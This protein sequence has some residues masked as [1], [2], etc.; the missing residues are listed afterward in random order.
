MLI[1]IF[2][3]SSFDVLITNLWMCFFVEE[4]E[5]EQRLLLQLHHGHSCQKLHVETFIMWPGWAQQDQLTALIE[6]LTVILECI[7]VL[8]F[9]LAGDSQ[10]LVGPGPNQAH[11]GYTTGF[12]I[13]T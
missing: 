3:L 11:L 2:D 1:K 12:D 4:K 7:D 13:V 10:I 8:K 9:L 6:Y 5:T